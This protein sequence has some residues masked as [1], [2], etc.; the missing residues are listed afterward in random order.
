MCLLQ[1]HNQ[2][3]SWLCPLF[4]EIFSVLP[5]RARIDGVPMAINPNDALVVQVRSV[6]AVVTVLSASKR[7]FVAS[8]CRFSYFG[9]EV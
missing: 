8:L 1:R 9:V 5:S 3:D 7:I 4:G 2:L 6:R